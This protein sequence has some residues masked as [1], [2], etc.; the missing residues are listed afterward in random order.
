MERKYPEQVGDVLR[1]LLEE[2][3]LKT[4]MEELHAAE[5]WPK[6]AGGAIAEECGKPSVR[7]G[8]M[9]IGVK[10]AALRNELL[11]SRSGFISNIN[12]CLG[13]EIIKEIRF[14]S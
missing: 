1:S 10:N 8:V 12:R 14:T 5:L 2:T 4:R 3:S 11:M 7:N 6:V 9:S 13:K